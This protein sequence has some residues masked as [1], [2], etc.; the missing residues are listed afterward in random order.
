MLFFKGLKP[1]SEPPSHL[2]RMSAGTSLQER[3]LA[4]WALTIGVR[5]PLEHPTEGRRRG[6]LADVD[7]SGAGPDPSHRSPLR[8]LIG[9]LGEIM[10]R[11][12]APAM[13]VSG[14]MGEGLGAAAQ[15]SYIGN[16]GTIRLDSPGRPG[17][18]TEDACEHAFQRAA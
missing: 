11:R 4:A 7:L 1:A 9:W 6:S 12:T 18:E 13:T 8:R 14:A 3:K 2:A 5:V 16:A 10:Q 15:A 17:E